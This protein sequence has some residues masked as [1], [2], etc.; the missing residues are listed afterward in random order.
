MIL[1]VFNCEKSRGCLYV[2]AYNMS[3]VKQF[4]VGISGLSRKGIEMVPYEEM[5]QLLKIS[6]EITETKL[7]PH[8]WVRVK[9]GPYA[10]DLGIVELI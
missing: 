6:S 2:E 3:H 7:K 10:G 1:S 9:Y 5:T 8:Q 4:I